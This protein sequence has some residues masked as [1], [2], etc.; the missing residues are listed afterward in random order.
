VFAE[1]GQL[2][3]VDR[4]SGTV[5]WRAKWTGATAMVVGDVDGDGTEELVVTTGKALAL[6]RRSNS[7]IL[8][9]TP[10]G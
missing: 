7:R 6:L 3:L 5:R 1:S 4:R 10:A 2:L 9:L 8:P